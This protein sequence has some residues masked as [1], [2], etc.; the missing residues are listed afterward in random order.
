MA[1]G[2]LHAD[3]FGFYEY[4]MNYSGS[5]GGAC[6]NDALPCQSAVSFTVF[7]N[8][9]FSSV[10]DLVENSTGG[11]HVSPFAVDIG[12]VDAN[13]AVTATGY[14]GT[15]TAPIPEP[16]SLLLLGTGV[17]GVAGLARRRFTK[18]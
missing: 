9:G 15:S 6:V 12:L 16:T 10:F 5:N 17:L 18:N 2:S 7:Q 4:G 3:G 11:G 1:P 14:V 8:G 13:G